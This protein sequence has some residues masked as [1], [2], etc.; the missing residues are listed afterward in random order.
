MQTKRGAEACEAIGIL[1]TLA[2]R[3]VPDHWQASCTYPDI[4][5]RLCKAHPLRDLA[6]IEERSQQGWAA[7]MAQWLVEIKAAVAEARP[8]QRQRP[9]VQSW[10][11]WPRARPGD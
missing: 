5:H 11:S 1:P 8:G 6:C 10:P 4:S 9:E 2:G 7:E 3:A